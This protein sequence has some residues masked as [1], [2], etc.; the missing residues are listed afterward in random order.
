MSFN[1]YKTVEKEILDCLQAKELGWRYETGSAITKKYRDGDEAEMLLLPILRERLKA[2]N[3]GVLTDEARVDVVIQK[4]RAEKDNGEWMAWLRGEKT[5]SFAANENAQ[6]IRLVDFSNPGANDFLCTNQPW[7]QGAQ[8]RRPDIL[9]YLNGVPIV[10]IEAKTASYGYVDWAEG[11]KQCE[12]YDREIAPLYYSNAFCVGVNEILMKY[13]TPGQKLQNWQVWRDP[14]PHTHINA[15]QH[16]EMK[17]TLYGMFDRANLLDILA[18]FIVFESESGRQTKKV[19]RY[20]QFRAANKIVER[21]L[22]LTQPREKRR[23]IVWHTQGSGKSLTMIFA[24]RK[25]WNH[26]ALSQPTVV[27][28]VDREQLEDQ[29][30]GDL[31]RTGTENVAVANSIRDLQK[32]LAADERGVILTIVNKFERM[33]TA[34]STR[35][36]IIVLADEAHRSQYGDLGIFMRSA[37][38]QASLFGLTGTPLELD[39]RNTAKEFGQELGPD[40][41]ER[42]MDKYSIGDAIKDGATKELRYQVRLT[43]WTVNGADLDIKFEQLFKDNTK[44]ERK[45][46]LGEARLD[47][48]L[49]HP[50][51]LAQVADD[52]A[53]HFT[54]HVRP[55]GFKAMVVCRDKE[56]CALYKAALDTRLGEAASKV[57]ISEDLSR[58]PIIVQAH[59]LGD[60][61]RKWIE[62][63]KKP[64]PQSEEEK[65]KPDAK[66]RQTEIFIVCD[67][68]TTGFDAPI[69]QTMYLDRGLKNH[70]LLQ[71]IARVNRPYTELKQFGVVFDYFGVFENL[72]EALNYDQSELGEIAF[73]F[74]QLRG[75][76][77]EKIE[78]LL[79]FFDGIDRDGSHASLMTALLRIAGNEETQRAFEKRFKEVKVLYETLSPDEALRPYIGSYTWLVKLHMIYRKKFYPREHFE[80]SDEDGARTRELIRE[81]VDVPALNTEFPTYVLDENY[82]FKLQSQAPDA[83]AL[84]IEAMLDA[85]IRIRLDEDEEMRPLSEKLNRIIEQKRAG[86]LAG[87]RLLEE[88]E[89]LANQTVQIVGEAQRPVE[90]TI[91]GYVAERLPDVSAEDAQG[92]ANALLEAARTTCSKGWF[93]FEDAEKTLYTAFV[94]TLFGKFKALNL[95]KT[96]EGE[97]NFA[98]RVV[99]LLK[100]VRFEG[101]G[102]TKTSD[103]EAI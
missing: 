4:L 49:K 64:T 81:H 88:L 95:H 83:K 74:T 38:P 52:I 34:I 11:A 20:Q 63:F 73:P 84:D 67:K 1:E 31:S 79:A 13:G 7:I 76:F 91:A 15:A 100:K 32:R 46:L 33:P 90:Q 98:E 56:A 68:L 51:R 9:L 44:E 12:R 37:L 103:T 35:A 22:Q 72:N 82:L 75:R 89:A 97:K 53:A 57:V 66:Y 80:V 87:V 94:D 8:R 78:E 41:F 55:N 92:V 21:A 99:K 70:S 26:P 2:L 10:D 14:S 6:N 36:N 30:K 18:N 27:I 19:A 58:D 59:Y 29:M 60:D 102:G 48:I 5:L 16:G 54:Q 17:L 47:A 85:E 71:A 69:L 101:E 42:Y 25:L 40:R 39:D 65:A 3:P 23:G 43:D 86:T 93:T 77:E 50:K 61:E 24:A 62:G 96:P 45:K 28:V